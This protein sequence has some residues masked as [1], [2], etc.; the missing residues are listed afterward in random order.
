MKKI[1]HFIFGLQIG[2]AESYLTSE[3][4]SLE[5]N[6]DKKLI[7]LSQDENIRN[8]FFANLYKEKPEIFNFIPKYTKNPFKHI[9]SLYNFLKSH[10]QDYVHIHANSFINPFP[11]I[12]CKLLGIKSIMHSHNTNNALGGTIGKVIHKINRF[13]FNRFIDI[14]IS[15]G[16]DAG[17]WMFSD[18]N[19][20][21]IPN[22][23]DIDKY[24]F[25]LNKRDDVR[26]KYGL[27]NKITVMGMVSRLHPQKNHK[28]AIEIFKE[29]KKMDSTSKLMIVGDGDL[30]DELVQYSKDLKLE[31]DIIY[32][33][34]QNDTASYYSAFDILLFPS[35]YE[36][37]SI[38]A[39]EAQCS[40]LPILFSKNVPQEINILNKMS[41][42]SLKDDNAKWACSIHSLL[43]DN[44][45]YNRRQAYEVLS[46]SSYTYGNLKNELNNI[47][48][49][50]L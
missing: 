29:Y 42:I 10:P 19:F 23:I 15:C 44:K 50:K 20:K 7:I 31:K 2:G 30:K 8:P 49:S 28:R 5:K 36:G 48:D 45:N 34:S 26:K 33:G 38:T 35:L 9:I 40:G 46:N 43:L 39:I 32:C 17:A 16:K 3:F 47:Y 6:Q 12:V 14:R 4:K 1:L 27:D 18:R 11:I 37:L 13:L 41:F 24:I 21:I 22:S 25:D